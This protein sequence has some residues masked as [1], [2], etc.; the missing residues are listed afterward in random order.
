MIK[1]PEIPTSIPS[2]QDVSRMGVERKAEQLLERF[3]KS[4]AI[5]IAEL[6]NRPDVAQAV[7]RHFSTKGEA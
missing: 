2:L 1:T 7:S 3:S 4:D 5:W 6:F